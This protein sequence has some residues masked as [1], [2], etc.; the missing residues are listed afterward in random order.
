MFK[1]GDYVVHS[2]HGVCLVLGL[3]K[4]TMDQDCYKL[5]TIHNGMTILIP[6]EKAS[7]YLRS[8]LSMNEIKKA[9]HKTTESKEEYI[10]DNKE[11]K[12]YFQ[13]LVISNDICDTILLLKQLYTLMGDKKR[14]KKNLGSFDS[15]FLQQAERKLFNEVAIA[16]QISKDEAQNYIYA[17]LKAEPV[18]S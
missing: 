1:I 17:E 8:I 6:C 16:A 3:V 18:L 9:I 12:V 15:Q 11:R 13:S 10:K 14:E 7:C 4:N 5:Q 2:G